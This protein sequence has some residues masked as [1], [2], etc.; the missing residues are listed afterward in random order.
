MA[1]CGNFSI[2]FAF[3][4]L[5]SEFRTHW[6]VRSGC[7]ESVQ[8]WSLEGHHPNLFFRVAQTDSTAPPDPDAPKI[9]IAPKSSEHA[10]PSS[11]RRIAWSGHLRVYDGSPMYL[12]I[13]AN[14]GERQAGVA[15]SMRLGHGDGCPHCP[16]SDWSESARV[17]VRAF[18]ERAGVCTVAFVLS[19]IAVAANMLSYAEGKGNIGPGSNTVQL[20]GPTS[21]NTGNVTQPKSLRLAFRSAPVWAA[22]IASAGGQCA[23]ATTCVIQAV[24]H[25]ASCLC[26]V[27]TT[28]HEPGCAARQSTTLPGGKSTP[29]STSQKAQDVTPACS[30][31]RQ[32]AKREEPPVGPGERVMLVG[33]PSDCWWMPARAIAP[34]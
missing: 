3:I 4:Q 22:L 9:P 21:G 8:G 33:G 13:P 12:P 24:L 15:Q 1:C 18:L 23:G 28:K 16:R 20:I 6:S 27:A 10:R 11:P 7:S 19:K 29:R 32:L 14:R 2:H 26:G 17:R 5:I 30:L 34:P 25:T 31:R